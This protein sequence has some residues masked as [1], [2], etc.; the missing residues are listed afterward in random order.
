MIYSHLTMLKLQKFRESN[1][2]TKEIAIELI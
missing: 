2:S 1:V